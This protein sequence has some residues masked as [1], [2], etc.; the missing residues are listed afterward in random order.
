MTTHKNTH[1]LPSREQMLDAFLSSDSSFD[2]LFY[3][4]V[5]TTGIFCRPSCRARKPRP[6][7]VEFHGTSREAVFAGYRACKRCHPLEAPGTPP[8]WLRPLLADLERDPDRRRTDAELAAGG[9][10]PERVRRWF[11]AHHGMTFQAYQ[12]GRRLGRAITRL[13]A[14]QPV[15]RAAM[16]SGYDS[17]SGFN[18]AFRQLAGDSPARSRSRCVVHICRIATPLGELIAGATDDGLCLAEF[19]ER[20][21]LE[22]Q[23]E[24]LRRRLDAVLTPGSHPLLAQL[25]DQ[26]RAYFSGQLQRFRLP[27]QLPGTDFQREVWQALQQIPYG[28]TTSY[29]ALARD[30]GRP[31]AVRAVARA[32]GDNRVAILVPCHRVLGS[33]GSLTGYGGG[34]WRKQRLL[35]IEGSAAPT[36]AAQRSPSS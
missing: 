16:D 25:D 36:P 21:G 30:I 10:R 22:R 14:G 34:L 24:T 19:S 31:S 27:L 7:N 35:E 15:L 1:A 8:D 32:N 12:R 29:A 9:L 23:Q 28:E 20:R 13:G 6:E 17:L 4:C 26:L 18:T 2:G 11:V 3:T 33:D 5:R